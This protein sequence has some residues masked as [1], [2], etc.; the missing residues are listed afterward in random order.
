ME[1]LPLIAT[2]ALLNLLA[3]VSPGPDFVMT[4]RNSLVYSRRTGIYTGLGI[5]AGLVV[6][7]V[8]CAAGIGYLISKSLVLF[9]ILKFLG[10]GYLVYM[11]VSAFLSRESRVDFAGMVH[12]QDIS[13]WI[14]FRTGF[15]TNV[16]NPKATLFFL[17]LFSFVIGNTTPL[18]VI[19]VIS[20]IILATAFTWFTIVS[21]FFTSQKIRNAFLRY[22]YYINR[23][24]GLFLILLGIKIAFA[25]R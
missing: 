1:Y 5:T 9:T 11:G 15:F 25:L 7:L 16:L 10:A 6:H 13:R 17:S 14:A 3:A 2:V 24:L 12:V 19:L 20:L 4:V 8:Y 18:V 21:V 23:V 22:E